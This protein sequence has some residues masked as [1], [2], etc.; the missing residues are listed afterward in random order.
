MSDGDNGIGD[1][2]SV[3]DPKVPDGADNETPPNVVDIVGHHLGIGLGNSFDTFN[4]K[5]KEEIIFEF[6]DLEDPALAAPP[7]HAFPL[8][9]YIRCR[10]SS[11]RWVTALIH[12]LLFIAWDL[13]PYKTGY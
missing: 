13:W 7:F 2:V 12:K 1:E 5:P 3:A 9:M 10:R 8:C 11:L 4:T 6:Q